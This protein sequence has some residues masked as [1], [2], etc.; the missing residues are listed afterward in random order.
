MI[1]KRV[2]NKQYVFYIFIEYVAFSLYFFYTQNI[3]PT[4]Q[5]IDIRASCSPWLTI[6]P[7]KFRVCWRG[8]LRSHQASGGE[9]LPSN[10][11]SPDP[12]RTP[13]PIPLP[14]N[15]TVHVIGVHE[16]AQGSNE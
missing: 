4:V 1:L 2:V 8:S 3:Y 10:S 7:F 9:S 5:P 6:D 13:A 11:R 12:S 16:M 15:P 14:K